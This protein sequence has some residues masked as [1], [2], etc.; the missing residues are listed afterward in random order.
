MGMDLELQTYFTKPENI[1]VEDYTTNHMLNEQYYIGKTIVDSGAFKDMIDIIL[2]DIEAHKDYAKATLKMKQHQ[3]FNGPITESEL[4]DVRKWAYDLNKTLKEDEKDYANLTPTAFLD[5]LN[6]KDFYD[7]Y[8]NR[9]I[10]TFLNHNI[11]PLYKSDDEHVIYEF[12]SNKLVMLSLI[13]I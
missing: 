2:K 12:F 9:A 4:D 13:H 3:M 7:Y 10:N 8:I 5:M 1:N 11:V 6:D